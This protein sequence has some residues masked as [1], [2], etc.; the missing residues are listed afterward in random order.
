MLLDEAD[1]SNSRKNCILAGVVTANSRVILYMMMDHVGDALLYCDTGNKL[2]IKFIHKLKI[3]IFSDSVIFTIKDGHVPLKTGDL[4]GELTDEC[5]VYS[6]P[7]D[8]PT[9]PPPYIKSFYSSGPKSYNLEIYIPARDEIKHVRKIKGFTLNY[10]NQGVM[11]VEP[12]KQLIKGELEVVE[13]DILNQIG[14]TSQ[15]EIYTEK[16]KKK[17]MRLVFTKRRRVGVDKTLPFGTVDD[18]VEK[19]RPIPRDNPNYRDWFA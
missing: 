11:G 3:D 4:L 14:R 5:A 17:R 12:L 7:T 19:Y 13:V 8:D 1:V 9:A 15:F 16:N 18:A 6:L 2:K 10:S